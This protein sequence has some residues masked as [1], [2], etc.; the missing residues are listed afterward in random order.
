MNEK[1]DNS[2]SIFLQC[3]IIS[4][5]KKSSQT[6]SDPP[7]TAAAV[8]G[9]GAR[10]TFDDDGACYHGYVDAIAFGLEL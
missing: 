1:S 4:K 7:Y 10:F 3:E 5:M 6:V 2:W 9:R 8:A